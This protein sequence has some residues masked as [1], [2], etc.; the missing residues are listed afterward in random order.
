MRPEGEVGTDGA[1]RIEG[2][3]VELG[4]GGG[5]LAGCRAWVSRGVCGI[6][7]VSFGRVCI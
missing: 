3:K 4:G 2:E 5:R 6:M 7:R 1:A